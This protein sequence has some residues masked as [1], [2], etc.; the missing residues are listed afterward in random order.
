MTDDLKLQRHWTRRRTV[1]V[2]LVPT[3]RHYAGKLPLGEQSLRPG[4]PSTTQNLQRSHDAFYCAKQKQFV[5][6]TGALI[7][8]RR[9]PALT[10]VARMST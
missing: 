4:L 1:F 2:D 9:H 6:H 10:G 7:K 8:V 5:A 3:L